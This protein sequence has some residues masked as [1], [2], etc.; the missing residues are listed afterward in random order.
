MSETSPSRSTYFTTNLGMRYTL[1]LRVRYMVIIG[2]GVHLTPINI[3]IVHAVCSHKQRESVVVV[4]LVSYV[5]AASCLQD[6]FTK[7]PHP[8][9]CVPSIG[10][11]IHNERNDTGRS[12]MHLFNCNFKLQGRHISLPVHS[13]IKC[14]KA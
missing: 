11:T 1:V 5:V 7:A 9:A 6:Y 14:L 12:T 10:T 13:T 8:I 3:M 4:L 2:Y